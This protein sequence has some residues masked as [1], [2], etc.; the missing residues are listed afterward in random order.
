MSEFPRRVTTNNLIVKG[1]NIFKPGNPAVFR[2]YVSLSYVSHGGGSEQERS[3]ILGDG[4]VVVARQKYDIEKCVKAMDYVG[5]RRLVWNDEIS[6]DKSN[7]DKFG[8]D[9]ST[10]YMR[11]IGRGY[12]V[13]DKTLAV[14]TKEDAKILR[15]MTSVMETLVDV[16]GKNEILI[17]DTLE[18]RMQEV[19]VKIITRSPFSYWSRAW[20]MQEQHMS[21]LVEYVEECEDKLIPVT[22]SSSLQT[23]VMGLMKFVGEYRGRVNTRV[24]DSIS[25]AVNLSALFLSGREQVASLNTMMNAADMDTVLIWGLTRSPRCAVDREEMQMALC[26][27][28]NIYERNENTRWHRILSTFTRCGYVPI[29]KFYSERDPLDRW[30]PCP[31]TVYNNTG[32]YVSTGLTQFVMYNAQNTVSSVVMNEG[33]SLVVKAHMLTLDIKEALEVEGGVILP[34]MN[35]IMCIQSANMRVYDTKFQVQNAL[36]DAGQVYEGRISLDKKY[37]LKKSVVALYQEEEMILIDVGSGSVCGSLK[38]D[39]GHTM[40]AKV[41]GCDEIHG[42]VRAPAYYLVLSG[43]RYTVLNHGN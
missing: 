34:M 24:I 4:R 26:I 15:E 3:V 29:K 36:E 33:G 38:L 41:V 7:Y 40:S 13:A 5:G 18:Q 12:V 27:A 19:G 14:L 17:D 11:A 39:R 37:E 6:I 23:M 21:F 1:D 43:P 9:R 10:E 28:L 42:I 22:T 2:G 8:Q 35:G 20:T 31:T 25:N 30:W 16:I 32:K